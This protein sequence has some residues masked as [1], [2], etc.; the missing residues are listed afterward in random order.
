MTNK[1]DIDFSLLL[2]SSLV[3]AILIFIFCATLL[4]KPL[5]GIPYNKRSARRLSGDVGTMKE[6]QYRRQWIWN[7]PSK[8]ESPVSQI[9]IFPFRMPTVIVTDYRA[10]IEI[11]S[12]RLGEFDRGTRNKE[13]IGLVAPNFHL[14]MHTKDPEFKSHKSLAQGLMAGKALTEISAAQIYNKADSLIK[15]WAVKAYISQ[16]NPFRAD[17]DIYLA[18]LDIICTV[19]FGPGNLQS[20]LQKEMLHVKSDQPKLSR[21]PM[22]PV[23]F[24]PAPAIP[25]LES[26]LNATKMISVAQSSMF[27]GVSQFLA[28][29]NP[30]NELAYLNRK[31]FIQRQIESRLK[32]MDCAGS[33]EC[34]CALDQL[35]RREMNDASKA[36]RLP[37][38]Y[39]GT[40]RDEILGYLI[41]G[42]D[43]TAA[44]MSWWVKYMSEHQLVQSRLRNDLRQGYSNAY[45]DSRQ[46][47]VEEIYSI[48]VPYLDAVIEETLRYA[49]VA[50]LIV[51]TSTCDTQICGY[52]IPK[53]VDVMLSLTGPSLTEPAIR[54]PRKTRISS[55]KQ[56]MKDQI[57]YWGDDIMQF[58]PERWLRMVKYADGTEAEKFYQKAGPSLAFSSGPRQCSGKNLAYLQ[59]RMMMVLIIWNFEL[60]PLQ[61]SL[62][63]P[64][65]IEGLVNIPKC[66]YVKLAEV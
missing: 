64:E 62:N 18:A 10:V 50:T 41:A 47:S 46:P 39:S 8:H 22:E 48:V 26:L 14:V 66:C 27:P 54:T 12:Q 56:K 7:Q 42:H 51:R 52:N 20:A 21:D 29:L 57:P 55:M 24:S 11:C 45:R 25:E 28:L 4:P 43:T 3:A 1:F 58:K 31:L 30:K 15:L 16:G 49:S 32:E 2:T 61:Q 5:P 60:Q 17:R 38:F 23:S 59:L 13:C 36:K 6:A 35:L 9:F 53:G 65:I 44:T 19:A 40:I 63:G 34:K 33:S 37:N